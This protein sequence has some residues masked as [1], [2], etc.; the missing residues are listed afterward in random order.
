MGRR[1]TIVGKPDTNQRL[2]LNASK[3]RIPEGGEGRL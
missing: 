3:S 2:L 1:E